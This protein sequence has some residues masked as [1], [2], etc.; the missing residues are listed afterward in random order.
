MNATNGNDQFHHPKHRDDSNVAWA[1]CQSRDNH[2][3]FYAPRHAKPVPMI[4]A[5]GVA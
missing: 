3:D 1:K 2:R 4:Q 5:G